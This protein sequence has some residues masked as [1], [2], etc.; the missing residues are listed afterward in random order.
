MCVRGQEG[1]KMP[2]YVEAFDKDCDVGDRFS[3]ILL[4]C[5]SRAARTDR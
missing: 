3:R 5:C 2:F 1:K 4:A